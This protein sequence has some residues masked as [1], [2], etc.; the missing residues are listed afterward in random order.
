MTEMPKYRAG[1]RLW[2]AEDDAIMRERYPHESTKAV[3]SALGR[4][5]SATYNRA[6][7]LGLCKT[8]EYLASPEACRLRR[9]DNIGAAIPVRKR[10]CTGE[11]RTAASRLELLAG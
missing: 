10:T 3:A 1:K 2:S 7:I 9:G 6:D 8:E 11:Q 4:S 5:V